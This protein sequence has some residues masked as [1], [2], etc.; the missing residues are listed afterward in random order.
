[1]FIMVAVLVVTGFLSSGQEA[2]QGEE[3]PADVRRVKIVTVRDGVTEVTDTLIASG[4]QE[5]F[6]R[7]G[8]RFHFSGNDNN[9]FEWEE[10]SADDSARRVVVR[11]N[12][13]HQEGNRPLQR[14]QDR[15]VLRGMPAMQFMRQRQSNVIDLADPGIIS[16]KKKKLR[17]GQEKITI[18]RKE[19]PEREQES[20]HFRIDSEG[21]N[22]FIPKKP[23]PV[24]EL[25]II[26]KA[27]GEKIEIDT[28][29]PGGDQRTP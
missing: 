21:D 18:I 26:R 24:R 6:V 27:P 4:K 23:R 13:G 28:H 7:G 20:L 9:G 2:K 22:L 29:V 5:I 10:I 25:E 16:F 12:F 17:N 11:R 3:R 8:N 15:M 19:A 14:S 1:M